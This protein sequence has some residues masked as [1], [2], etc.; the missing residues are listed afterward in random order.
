[1]KDQEKETKFKVKLLTFICIMPLTDT[2]SANV[3]F[4]S[5]FGPYSLIGILPPLYGGEAPFLFS[6]RFEVLLDSLFSK[7]LLEVEF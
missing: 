7:Y 4:L 6:L 1:M 2:I 5:S 3:R